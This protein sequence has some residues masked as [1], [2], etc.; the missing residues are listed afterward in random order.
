M[1]LNSLR[2]LQKF[3]G[4]LVYLFRNRI[5]AGMP[6]SS[7]LKYSSPYAV[8]TKE[9][10]VGSCLLSRSV[11]SDSLQPHGLQPA[12]R[13]CPCGFY[14]QEYWSVLPRPPPRDLPNP[15]IEPRSLALQVDSLLSEPPGKPSST[16]RR[17]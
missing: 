17:I 3:H 10:G 11:V 14:R 2:R 7:F 5:C 13:L 12:R 1:L 16:S 15:R 8:N 4:D 6:K 9:D